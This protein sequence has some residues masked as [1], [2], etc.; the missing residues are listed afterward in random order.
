[1]LDRLCLTNVASPPRRESPAAREE[2]LARS[3]PAGPTGGTDVLKA[4]VKS[5]VVRC[6]AP[7]GVLHGVCGTMAEDVPGTTR[8]NATQRDEMRWDETGS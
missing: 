5:T 6:Y 7:T 1:M 8:P 3:L 4:W 2:V